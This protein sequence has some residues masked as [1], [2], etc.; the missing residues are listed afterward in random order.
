MA[1]STQTTV[2]LPGGVAPFSG[3]NPLNDALAL[4]RERGN[5]PPGKFLDVGTS[6]ST[7]LLV[8]SVMPS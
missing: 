4:G 5:K 2:D 3:A 8:G 1:V 6:V 7:S